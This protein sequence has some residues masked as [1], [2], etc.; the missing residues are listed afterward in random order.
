M[1][2]SDSLQLDEH[3]ARLLAAYDQGIEGGDGKAATI[4]VAPS[5][6]PAV[7]KR[8]AEEVVKP[9]SGAATNEGS[10]GELLPE[11]PAPSW[12][13][14]L[15]VTP[16]PAVGPH[17]IGR[18]ELRRQLGKGGCG[19]VFLAYDPKLEREVALK[20]PRPEML[21]SPDARRRLVREALAAAEFD[22]PNLVPVYETGEIGPVCYIATA[23]CPGQTL[24]EWL[25]KQAY[26][27]PVRQAARLI[28]TVAEAV[29]HAHDRG[30]LHRDLKPNNV[31]LQ[32]AKDDPQDPGAPPGSCQLRGD[33]FTPRVVDFGL[34]KLLERGGPSET[35]TRQV[36]GTP[37]YM[38]PE[39]AQARHEDVGPT[40]DVYA[41][42]VMLYEMLAGCAPYEGATDVDVLRQAIEGRFTHPRHIRP[43]IPRDLE[44]ICLKAMDRTPAGRYRT[45]ID[46]ADDL[47]RFL[48][49]KP[50]LARPLKWS[51]RA[52]KWLRRNDQVVALAV[53]TTI[54]VVLLAVGGWYVRQTRQLKSDQDRVAREQAERT[55]SD[56]RREYAAHVR[57][58]FLAL[59]SGNYP[60]AAEARDAAGRVATMGGDLPDFTSRYLSGLLR[61]E[62]LHINCPAGAV[63]ALAV[64]ADGR[65]LASGHADGTISLW[66]AAGG[67]RLAS[68]QAHPS[69]VTRLLF[70]SG[71]TRLVSVGEVGPVAENALCWTVSPDGALAPAPPRGGIIAGRV[72]SAD[73]S[74]DGNTLYAGTTDGRL[75]V[76]R[77]DDPVR[78]DSITVEVGGR[79]T[80]V[81]VTSAGKELLV[82]TGDGRVFRYTSAGGDRRLET[83]RNG[84]VAA[85]VPGSPPQGY[86]VFTAD[87][88]VFTS[89]PVPGGLPPAGREGP[90][91]T[92]VV[93]GGV[94][95]NDGPGR[96]RLLADT[97]YVLSTGD[98]GA[99]RAG[100]ATRDGRVLFTAGDDGTIRSWQLPD[101][102]RGRGAWSGVDGL[103]IAV[104]PEGERVAVS[105]PRAFRDRFGSAGE[106][107]VSPPRGGFAATV[108]T[109]EGATLVVEFRDRAAVLREPGASPPADKVVLA[110][111]DNA[112]P[113]SAEF[114][115]DGTRLA[116]GDSRGRV[117]VWGVPDGVAVA[118]I[119]TGGRGPVRRVAL[120]D[121]GRLVAAATATGIAVWVVGVPSTPTAIPRPDVTAFRFLPGGD[122]LATAGEDGAV[123]VWLVGDGREEF[124]LIGHVGRVTGLGVSPDGRTLVSGGAA[125]EVLFWD[126]R[127]GQELMSVRRHSGP[128]TL[129]EFARNGK[130]LVTAGAGQVAFWEA[131][132]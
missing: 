39:Q 70:A 113:V 37:K 34:A 24:G 53:V 95:A 119:D 65:R 28:A 94:V 83:T 46:L 4:G 110:P 71:G 16:A 93:D 80:A 11:P 105:T 84:P 45:A 17:R 121:D 101:D 132:E 90:A 41:L 129:L 108:V 86:S 22:H 97:A 49:G 63:T 2:S 36:L 118:S 19:I 48:D 99:V 125:G 59:R 96:V 91:W 26:P 20:V 15:P 104:H 38:A 60:A 43:E 124:A 12:A 75:H 51:G 89:R 42:G 127:T 29:Q 21:L 74:P 64:S 3:L 79:V 122:R 87:G 98:S 126:V 58:T 128:V 109:R 31:I 40:A 103:A 35:H 27:V 117:S 112:S 52:L 73:L 61:R 10:L 120:S 56:Q 47:R 1:D 78:G 32:A 62:R 33:H 30:V 115:G 68:V 66:D 54:A 131:G 82:G 85:I 114:S 100:A 123:R 14:R 9:L 76:V 8:P 55:V 44:A 111:P 130:L 92:A 7:A 77:L 13:M 6:S 50:T 57:D 5:D 106:T 23:F 81:A 116:V 102:W 67:Q 107:A 72:L 18:F 88:S 69:A 25:E